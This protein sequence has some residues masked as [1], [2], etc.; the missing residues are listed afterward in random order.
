MMILR[1]YENVPEA[2]RGAVVVIGNFDGIHRG[3]QALIAKGRRLAEEF[4]A[5]LAVLTFEPHPRSY[6][7]P[8]QAPFLLTPFRVKAQLIAALG[9]DVLV[10]QRFNKAFA[11]LSA[12]DFIASVL[13]KGL[14]ARHVLVGENFRFGKGRAGD[15]DLLER[16][17]RRHGFAVT[18][19]GLAGAP[20]KT[21]PDKPQEVFSSSLVREY[22]RE[23]SPTRAALLLG[24]YWEIEG[25]VQTGARR[26]RTLGFPTANIALKKDMLR[27]AYGV[28][29]VRATLE[30]QGAPH[31][32]AGVANL[33][34]SP[35]FNYQEPLLEVYLFDFE[36]DLY[37]RNMRVALI[38][39]LRGEMTFDSLDD[40]KD[41]MAEDSRR[42]RATL[43]WEDWDAQWPAGPFLTPPQ[44]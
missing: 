30:G 3:H 1:H 8:D 38:D 9:V 42:A 11:S 23:G 5:P 6:F 21:D 34:L 36:G 31:W 10:V 17:G 25:R 29:A 19:M 39:Y 22:L 43:A 41:Q 28:Y 32:R 4:G 15:L 40:L 14:H 33:G 27:P 20:A 37:G 2:A 12:E 7:Q 16:E 24:R 18:G 44:Q 26:G 35:M 13:A